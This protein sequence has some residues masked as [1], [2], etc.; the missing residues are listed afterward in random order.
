MNLGFR[1]KTC[2]TNFVS[3]FN[4]GIQ[5]QSWYSIPSRV[6]NPESI[7]SQL[8]RVKLRNVWLAKHKS[9]SHTRFARNSLRPWDSISSLLLNHK[10]RSMPNN[11]F[12]PKKC[13]P[14]LAQNLNPK[15]ATHSGHCE[16]GQLQ[17]QN[18]IRTWDSVTSWGLTRKQRFQLQAVC[19][20]PSRRP[21]W[22]SWMRRPT[23][24]QE[25][26]GSTP[27]EIGNILS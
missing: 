25:V 6:Y 15:L 7:Q 2:F 1:N 16:T 10:Q 24:D 21:R 19:T 8:F 12:S 11:V 20:I 27:A 3:K 4:P 23:G 13:I 17:T 9:S 26:A 22:L 18:S 5:S 14:K